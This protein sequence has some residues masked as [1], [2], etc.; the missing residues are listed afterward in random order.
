LIPRGDTP[1]PEPLRIAIAGGTRENRPLV[2][3][4]LASMADVAIVGEAV[5]CADAARLVL[6]ARPHLVLIEL[7][8]SARCGLEVARRLAHEHRPLVAFVSKNGRAA[9]VAFELGAVDYLLQPVT[10]M[11]LADTL[12]RARRWLQ[13]DSSVLHVPPAG[14]DRLPVRRGRELL[15][16][17][18]DQIA[19]IVAEGDLL[20]ITTARNERHTVSSHRLKEVEARLDGRAFVRLSRSA[21]ANLRFIARLTPLAGGNY[22]ASLSNR[23]DLVVSRAQAR[24]LRQR[25]LRA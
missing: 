1:R 18:V 16:L 24:R 14:S 13:R 8:P 5:T 25:L 21:L 15:L 6:A 3:A 10:A 11:R 23:Q 22:V 12:A 19:S 17:P 2:G 7:E 9:A 20:H 4:L